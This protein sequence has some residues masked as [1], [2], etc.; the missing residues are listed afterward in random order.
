MARCERC[1]TSGSWGNSVWK[2]PL[3]DKEL[4]AGC[5]ES[6]GRQNRGGILGFGERFNCPK[7]QGDM[8]KI[9]W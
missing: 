8:R 4:C 2:C 6:T 3:C 9:A 1:G 7:C 5:L